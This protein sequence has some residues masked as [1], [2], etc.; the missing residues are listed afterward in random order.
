MY[1]LG[2]VLS[3]PAFLLLVLAACSAALQD[4]V[5]DAFMFAHNMY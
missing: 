1:E 2:A 3:A 4:V 5:Q